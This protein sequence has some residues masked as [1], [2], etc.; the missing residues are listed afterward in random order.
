[1]G[2]QIPVADIMCDACAA[3]FS[4]AGNC[5]DQ[6]N[7]GIVLFYLCRTACMF[8][9]CFSPRVPVL[10]FVSGCPE[11]ALYYGWIYSSHGIDPA[12]CNIQS[13]DGSTLETAMENIAST[14]LYYIAARAGASDMVDAQ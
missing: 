1:M 13:L 8:I 7:A 6:E 10:G 3:D 4:L 11:A 12:G 14:D 9:Y 2:A 5:Q